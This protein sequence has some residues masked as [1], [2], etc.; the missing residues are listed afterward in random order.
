M[1]LLRGVQRNGVVGGCVSLAAEQQEQLKGEHCK[2][3]SS[4]MVSIL[5]WWSAI[6]FLRITHTSER[7]VISCPV[8]PK[9][10]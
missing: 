2:S 9:M 1:S 6:D 10:L 4:S 3:A 7:R 8:W 5:L